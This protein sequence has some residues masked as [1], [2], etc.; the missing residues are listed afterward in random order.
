MVDWMKVRVPLTIKEKIVKKVLPE[1]V[2]LKTVP[3][4]IIEKIKLEPEEEKPEKKA[5]DIA[6][7]V[8]SKLALDPKSREQLV[9]DIGNRIAVFGGEDASELAPPG[10]LRRQIAQ[11]GEGSRE[12]LLHGLGGALGGGAMGAGIGALTSA[13]ALGKNRAALGTLSGIPGALAGYGV[14]KDRQRRK[15]LRDLL[16]K[17]AI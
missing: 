4:T 10:E 9:D 6:D 13:I 11:I 8:L 7:Q 14:F 17:N 3:A 12:Q 16:D 2:D 5:S 1:G 15:E